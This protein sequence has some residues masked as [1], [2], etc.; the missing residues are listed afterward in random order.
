MC[1]YIGWIEYDCGMVKSNPCPNT[2]AGFTKEI[3]IDV[4]YRVLGIRSYERTRKSCFE[5]MALLLSYTLLAIRALRPAYVLR[6][7]VVW[8]V[9]S[10]LLVAPLIRTIDILEIDRKC[11][12]TCTQDHQ[13]G[14]P[15]YHFHFFV[16][17]RPSFAADVIAT[18]MDF[19]PFKGI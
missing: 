12:Y 14:W 15:L 11:I 4:W 2:L 1:I 9:F 17:E 13:K 6:I 19:L 5:G 7:G 10:Y 16:C 3:C 18:E 8:C